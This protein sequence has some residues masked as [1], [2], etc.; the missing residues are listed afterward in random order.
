MKQ[1]KI[2]FEIGN[3]L[4]QNGMEVSSLFPFL[5]RVFNQLVKTKEQ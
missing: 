4:R 1:W 3:Q 5:K 2:A